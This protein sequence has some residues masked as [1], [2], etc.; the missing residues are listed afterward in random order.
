[1]APRLFRPGVLAQAAAA[2]A[3][4]AALS[5]C[6]A[7]G[8]SPDPDPAPA[9]PEGQAATC[10]GESLPFV[11]A[12]TLKARTEQTYGRFA[13]RAQ[14]P[15]GPAPGWL[16]AFWL[17]P[18]Q[19][20]GEAHDGEIDVVELPHLDSFAGDLVHHAAAHRSYDPSV[21]EDADRKLEPGWHTYEAI[22]TPTWIQFGV[23]GTPWYVVMQ[24]GA[25]P[26]AGLP[27][28][29]K[30]TEVP[31]FTEVF[32]KA[33]YPRFDLQATDSNWSGRPAAG[34]TFDFAIDW[35]ETSITK[36][37]VAPDSAKATWVPTFRDDFTAAHSATTVLD[38]AKWTSVEGRGGGS[39]KLACRVATPETLFI[40]DGVL[41]L[42]GLP[43][44][45][46]RAGRPAT[47]GAT[48]TR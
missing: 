19:G 33:Y 2:L 7:P 22:W 28:D 10:S 30:I 3:A 38:P 40:T 18:A 42:R 6:A 17:R 24:D 8:P 34:S 41:H 4:L 13:V 26:P 48:R 37:D 27:A 45:A 44:A 20:E 23:D 25:E 43:A 16:P 39:N 46:A 31:W 29:A 1:M 9:P 32:T 47:P 12:P 21:F 35:V 36:G 15:D 11:T 14:L 5:A